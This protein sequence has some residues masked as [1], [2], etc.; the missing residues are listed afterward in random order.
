[1]ILLDLEFV[2]GSS[3]CL[4]S[5]VAMACVLWTARLPQYLIIWQTGWRLGM[6]WMA[7]AMEEIPE[8]ESLLF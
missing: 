1:M 2:I 7:M 8:I 5:A 3:C 6:V 4:W